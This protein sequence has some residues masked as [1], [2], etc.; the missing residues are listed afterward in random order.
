MFECWGRKSFINCAPIPSVKEKAVFGIQTCSAPVARGGAAA[1]LET[2]AA[3]AA[4]LVALVTEVVAGART[5]DVAELLVACVAERVVATAAIVAAGVVAA[6]CADEAEPGDL[7]ELSERD[8]SPLEIVEEM[9][10]GRLVRAS[11]LLNWEDVRE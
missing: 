4:V 1:A 10:T 2:V 6:T 5:A 11:R 8:Y 7:S 3:G 9:A